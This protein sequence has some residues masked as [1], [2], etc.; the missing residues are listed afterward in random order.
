[1]IDINSNNQF[2]EIQKLTLTGIE[3]VGT[4]GSLIFG[5]VGAAI[6]QSMA[7]FPGAITLGTTFSTFA[8]SVKQNQLNHYFNS[9]RDQYFGIDQ[10]DKNIE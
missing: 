4:A 1:V 7:G 2:T 3:V 5:G 6:G 10:V 9:Y 8:D